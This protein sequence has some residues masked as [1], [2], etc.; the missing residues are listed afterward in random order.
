MSYLSLIFR[1]IAFFS[2]AVAC[3]L[4]FLTVD[5][6][7]EKEKEVLKIQA[8]LQSFID[9]NDS[10]S[11]E[12]GELQKKLAVK[13]K[14]VDEA[15]IQVEEAKAELVAEMQEGQ[16][17][18]NKLIESQKEVSQ[19]E[20]T[21]TRLRKE[22]LNAEDMYAASSQE[23]VIAQ[24]S[25]RIEE[26]T[27]ANNQLKDKILALEKSTGTPAQSDVQKLTPDEIDAIEEET[28]IASLSKA[29]GIIV[30]NADEKLNLKPGTL[31]K[32]INRSKVV[33]EIKVININGSLAIANILPG[34]QL[35][36]LSKGDTV[37]I[38]R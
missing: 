3:I 29:N 13:A 16:R 1:I 35:D 26:L 31:V 15:K 10:V 34:A 23:G 25:D 28:K 8:E 2:A 9:R 33:A 37:K 20:E 17:I 32:L 22:L 7:E 21:I 38:L 6:V 4:Y 12:I 30:L 27:T 24:L 36:E 5:K 11:L 14:L 19:L 18:Q